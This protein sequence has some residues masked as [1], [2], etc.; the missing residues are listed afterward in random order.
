MSD[1]CKRCFAANEPEVAINTLLPPPEGCCIICW[2]RYGRYVPAC[3]TLGE[4]SRSKE[5]TENE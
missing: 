4:L 3:R 2:V 5:A 1:F